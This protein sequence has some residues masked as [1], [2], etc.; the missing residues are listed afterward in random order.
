[1]KSL[2]RGDMYVLRL[3]R[4]ERIVE[5]LTDFCERQ[6]I[7]AGSFN[8]LG[9]CRNAELGFFIIERAAYEIRSFPEDY[10]IVALHGNVSL[11]EGKPLIHAHA[12]LSDGAFRCWGGHLREAEVLA[13]CEIFL[14]PEE[15]DLPRG[16][17]PQSGLRPLLD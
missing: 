10:E 9:T 5:A 2:K 8:G 12:V 17:N 4:G 3:E 6:G 1:M 11:L 14:R 15:G 13:T 7:R 16:N